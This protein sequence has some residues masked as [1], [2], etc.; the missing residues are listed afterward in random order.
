MED[1]FVLEVL[2]ELAE[3]VGN[4]TN[5]AFS[6]TLRESLKLKMVYIQ[7]QDKSSDIEKQSP[8]GDRK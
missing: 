4:K 7:E 1:M 5:H 6:A 2:L 8:F 3:S